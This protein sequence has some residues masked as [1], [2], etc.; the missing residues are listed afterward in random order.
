VTDTPILDALIG[1]KDEAGTPILDQLAGT[2]QSEG[3]LAA[4]SGAEWGPLRELLSGYTLGAGPTLSAFGAATKQ[5]LKTG[6]WS[7]WG[8][9]YDYAHTA[10]SGAKKKYEEDSP[11]GSGTAEIAGNIAGLVAPMGLATKA[12]TGAGNLLLRGAP[13]AAR[14]PLAEAG[15]FLT[16]AFRGGPF[17]VGT[18]ASRAVAGAGAGAAGNAMLT[19]QGETSAGD[20]ALVGGAVGAALGPLAPLIYR[21]AAN[22]GKGL[23]AAV[24]PFTKRG[25]EKI[26]DRAIGDFAA[27]GPT[28][29]RSSPVPGSEP[30][31]AQAT[32][33]PGLAGVERQLR[34]VAPNE[35]NAVEAGNM[36]A[37]QA[38]WRSMAG[39]PDTIT[40]M[41]TARETAT[42]VLRDR[43]FANAQPVNARSVVKKIDDILA[44]PS[45]KRDQVVSTLEGLRGK[46]EI[47]N[48]LNDRIDQAIGPI[49]ALLTGSRVTSSTDQNAL[50][51][52]RRLMNSAKRGNIDEAQLIDGLKSVKTSG[53]LATGA[54]AD[55]RK[56][57]GQG[58]TKLEADPEQLYGIRKSINDMLSSKAQDEKSKVAKLASKE[59][60]EVRD[61]LDRLLERSAPGF[62]Q[63]LR[64]YESMSRPIDVQQY[65]QGLNVTD[66]AGNLSV[67]GVDQA[68]KKIEKEIA[69]SGVNKAKSIPEQALDSL[70]AIRDDLRMAGSTAKGKAVGS[71]TVQNLVLQNLMR[72][73]GIETGL[74]KV[75]GNVLFKIPSLA[76]K[77]VNEDLTN[78]LLQ[79]M[80]SPQTAI[81]PSLPGGVGNRVVDNL[82]ARG[83]PRAMIPPTNRLQQPSE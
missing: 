72:Q 35:F 8:K 51:E 60:I 47:D 78:L 14:A 41:E 22:V 62:K 67:R 18:G 48:P 44:S 2:N 6:D 77:S 80:L 21:G 4:N 26:V 71:D 30:T 36:D 34:N 12:V 75:S 9:D 42:T 3:K 25:Q 38:L 53:K 55:A 5:A 45:G 31:L 32:G 66:A 73:A 49:K 64:T 52:V 68:I 82:L 46:L 79:K 33:N 69:K 7:N 29:A 27:G 39:T 1:K 65:L 23:A 15:N 58:D 83:A 81:Q 16:G 10:Y 13:Q 11:V 76:Y 56:A 17:G 20:N 59:L 37:R 28:A 61:Q 74:G 43:A 40:Q 70:N 50:L 19:G 63:Y 24:E 54:V 57:I